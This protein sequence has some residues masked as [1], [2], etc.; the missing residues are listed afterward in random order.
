MVSIRHVQDQD[1][2]RVDDLLSQV[3]E[4]HAGIRPDVFIPGT[5]KYTDEQLLRIFH[6]PQTPV[7]T[8]VSDEDQVIGYAFCILKE[9]RSENMYP[10]KIL[11]IDDLCVDQT[12]RGQHVGE[13]LIDYVTD[14][15]RQNGCSEITLNVWNGNDKAQGFYEKMGF[16]VRSL[17]LEK[18]L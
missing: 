4:I 14:F 11:Y 15:A 18:K 6:D 9:T 2:S 10:R 5:R 8:A 13:S 7:F 3:L 1:L 17:I 12:C 16:G